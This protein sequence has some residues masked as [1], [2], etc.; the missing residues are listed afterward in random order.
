MILIVS[1]TVIFLG[2]IWAY[3][4]YINYASSVWMSLNVKDRKRLETLQNLMA[5]QKVPI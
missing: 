5:H 4:L 3:Q 1:I 2:R